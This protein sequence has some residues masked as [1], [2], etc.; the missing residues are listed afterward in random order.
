M[1]FRFLISALSIFCATLSTTASQAVDPSLDP[2][3]APHVQ[4]GYFELPEGSSL[5]Q[6]EITLEQMNQLKEDFLSF[7]AEKIKGETRPLIIDVKWDIPYYTAHAKYTPEGLY[8]GLWGGFLRAPGIS[9]SVL[10]FTLCHELGHL[11]GG[12]P[13]QTNE[14]GENVTI[15]GASDFYSALRCTDQFLAQHPQYKPEISA[16]VHQICEGHAGC[17]DS[18]ESS[19]RTFRFLQKWG[20]ASYTPVQLAF[21]EPPAKKL[22][23]NT[24]PNYQC[25]IET[26]LQAALCLRDGQRQSCQ[27][28]P[29]W[30][31]QD[32]KFS[33]Y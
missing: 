29:C 26:S 19:F 10:V 5:P 31:P 6:S 30:W 13:K 21:I 2:D 18:L 28:P 4:R 15:E 22:I 3:V 11:V 23:L 25:R 33:S 1:N 20:F 8:I 7:A 16:T 14:L 27:P 17:S 12:E 9:P 24:Y 32:Q